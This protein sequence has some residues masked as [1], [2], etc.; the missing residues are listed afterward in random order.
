MPRPVR[1]SLALCLLACG[2]AV[3]SE[4]LPEGVVQIIPRGR[5]AAILEP[6]FVP[7]SEAEIA[8]D[9]WILGVSIEGESRAYSLNL[10]NRHEVVNDRIADRP[11]AAVW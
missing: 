1:P 10:L 2:V 9:A 8:D 11:V 7:A 5:I 3:A 6:V 4:E